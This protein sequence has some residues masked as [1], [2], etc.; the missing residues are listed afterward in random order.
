M[1]INYKKTK[2]MIFNP[3][4][5]IDFMPQ[6]ELGSY[7]LEVVEEMRVLGVI[8]QPNMKWEA[9]IETMVKKAFKKLLVIRRLKGLGD[10]AEDLVDMY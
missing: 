8:I 9:N 1:K 10:S 4:T 2:V 5:S 7:E 6:L 3:C